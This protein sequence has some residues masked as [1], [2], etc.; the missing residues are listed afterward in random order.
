VWYG[1]CADSSNKNGSYSDSIT[2]TATA[3]P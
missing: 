3:N 2:Y 1:V